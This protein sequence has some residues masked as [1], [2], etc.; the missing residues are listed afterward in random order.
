[1][2]TGLLQLV[3]GQDHYGKCST[4]CAPCILMTPLFAALYRTQFDEW[5][6]NVD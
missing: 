1:M 3:A 4:Y 2:F 6:K 5:T